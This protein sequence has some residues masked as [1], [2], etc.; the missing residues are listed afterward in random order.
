MKRY[1]TAEKH[2]K[3]N[4]KINQSKQAQYWGSKIYRIVQ[5]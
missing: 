3:N 2:N 5:L 4:N 1:L